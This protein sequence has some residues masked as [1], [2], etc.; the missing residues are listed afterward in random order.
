MTQDPNM[1]LSEDYNSPQSVYWCLK[2]FVILALPED[3]PFWQTPE[4]P[5]P[6]R[7]Y[8]DLPHYHL[9]EEPRQLLCNTPQH[10]FLLSSGQDT[11]MEHK[12]REAKYGK[13]AYSSAFAFS[14]PVG[15]LLHQM[16]PDSTLALS[17]DGGD[18][19]KVHW[20]PEQLAVGRAKVG[21]SGQAE[22]P[23]LTSVW[24][25]WKFG[26]DVQVRTTLVPPVPE[27]PGWHVRVHAVQVQTSADQ[28]WF[29]QLLCV[30]GGFAASAEISEG[31]SI[32]EKPCVQSL[33]DGA[34]QRGSEGWWKDDRSAL[35]ISSQGASGVIDLSDSLAEGS[36]GK[37]L[38]ASSE[39][40][41]MRVPANTNLL[42]QRTVLPAVKHSID[43]DG[44]GSV[45]VFATG[46]FAVE[47][48]VG[49]SHSEI[50]KLW[51][52]PPA[53]ITLL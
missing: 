6:S 39:G 41:V 27:H 48:V 25:P 50:V 22:L 8:P 17:F 45:F 11:K 18:S 34:L 35:V 31:V 12:A 3:H 44:E 10:H 1:Y 14:V 2:P 30:E 13:F 47:A 5:H 51:Q 24:K 21:S 16:A 32:F 36:D 38:K 43:I 26:L 29:R 53:T 19:W 4:E 28:S 49:K 46:V 23:T 20:S 15:P 42:M 33:Q 37:G 52:N 9:I 40:T 7:L